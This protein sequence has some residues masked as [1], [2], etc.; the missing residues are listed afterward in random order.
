M[1]LAELLLAVTTVV[2]VLGAT[3]GMLDAGHR[4]HTAATA[5]VEAYQ[6]ARVA[7]ERLARE[8]R[9][10]GQGLPPGVPAIA[11]AE[12]GRIVIQLDQDGD[13]QA[14][15]NNEV[16]TWRLAG[17]TLRRAAGAGAQ[18]VVD[19]VEALTLTYLDGAGAPA[20]SPADVRTVGIT[21]TT[22]ADAS[23]RAAAATLATS[24]H[25]RNR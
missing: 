16:I 6:T 12:A 15:A 14:L 13:G 9:A 25:L 23:A 20:A 3:L 2:L 10:A 4:A 1:S 8:I 21:L 24:V 11:V 7:L 19:N 5:R 17:T 22:R 18:P